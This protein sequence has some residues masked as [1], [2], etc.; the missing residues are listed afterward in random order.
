MGQSFSLRLLDDLNS[1]VGTSHTLKTLECTV[2][3][4]YILKTSLSNSR[5][6]DRTICYV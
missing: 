6:F 3:P 4:R 2:R 5:Q 1:R